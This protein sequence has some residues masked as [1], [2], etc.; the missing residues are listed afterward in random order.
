M[1]TETFIRPNGKPYKPRKTELTIEVFEGH[2]DSQCCV[3]FGTHD[4]AKATLFAFDTLVGLDLN[5]QNAH[6]GWWRKVPFDPS[7]SHYW[8]W[9][10]MDDP[11]R[12]RPCVIFQY[13]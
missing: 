7:G 6:T 2:D 1:A 12:G 13:S 9:T 10:F 4:L 11:V 8:D 3:V 5:P